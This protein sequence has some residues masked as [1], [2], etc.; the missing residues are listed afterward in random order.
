[1]REKDG[2][3][4]SPK[5]KFIK[6]DWNN[7]VCLIDAFEDRVIGFYFEPA[8]KLNKINQAFA[9][10]LISLSIIDLLA[11]NNSNDVG[12]HFKYWLRT[13]IKEFN[14][15]DPDGIYHNLSH[16]FYKEFRN[17]LIH[18]CRIKN[19]GQFSYT[20]DKLIKFI[21]DSDR[22]IMIVNPEILLSSLKIA[23][24]SYIKN[25]KEN[26]SEYKKFHKMMKN[27]FYTEFE[28]AQGGDLNKSM[29]LHN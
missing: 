3:Y 7:E 23:F 8:E 2:I 9:S 17:C 10:G 24:Q 12:F 4:F 19:A 16:R 25:I 5:Y 20:Y 14:R 13:N 11:S 29:D 27:N 22:H 28:R 21:H 26:E 18:E 6:L 15:P 1:M